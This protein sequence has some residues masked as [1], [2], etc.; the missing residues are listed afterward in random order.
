MSC[1]LGV[2]GLGTMGKNLARNFAHHGFKVGCFNRTY[3]K[4]EELLE[5]KEPNLVGFKTTEELVAEL[6]SPKVILLMVS[7]FAVDAVLTPLVKLLQKGDIV[8][9][10]GNS[11][12]KNTERRQQEILPTGVHFVGMGVSGGEEGALNGPS[13]MFG[14]EIDDWERCKNF[15]IPASAKSK[16]GEPCVDYMGK[17]GA[18]HFVKMVHNAIEYA[19]MQ[20]IVETYDILRKVFNLNSDQIADIFGKWNKTALQ[21]Y[22]IE[23][24]EE[25]LRRKEGDKPLVDL[26]LDRAAQ[27]GT[28]K[29]AAQ[30]SFDFSI[31]TPGFS[32]AV[33]ARVVSFMKEERVEASKIIDRKPIDCPID[34]TIDDLEHGLYSAKIAC[35]AQGLA[36]IQA[37][38]IQK[39]WGI[40]IEKC[41][42]IWRGGCI[43]R[44]Q[45]LDEISSHYTSDTKNLILVEHFRQALEERIPGW[46]KICAVATLK[47]IP[48]PLYASTLAYFDSY[49]SENLPANLLQGLRDFFGAHTYERIDKPGHFHTNWEEK[50]AIRI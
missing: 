16:N 39:N 40:H 30:D 6:K 38:S 45:F 12:W 28:G 15:L 9:D 11:Y 7:D 14:G 32:E 21:S 47:G 13:M 31:P 49:T 26:I 23:I 29:W 8:I 5:L 36:M 37:A 2:I 27:K 19:D 10:G 4:T 50:Q 33:S 43:I 48:I 1:E 44:A 24:T 25:V 42:K 35:Y 3:E 41:A 20:L 34:I 18:G 22:L 46:R 17:G